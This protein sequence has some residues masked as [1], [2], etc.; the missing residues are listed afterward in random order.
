[1]SHLFISRNLQ[2]YDYPDRKKYWKTQCSNRRTCVTLLPGKVFV[3]STSNIIIWWWIFLPNGSCGRC[4]GANTV[5]ICWALHAFHFLFG[6]SIRFGRFL[7]NHICVFYPSGTL[8]L[9]YYEMST[10]HD[11]QVTLLDNNNL[12]TT[13]YWLVCI[14]LP[15]TL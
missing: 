6:V 11:T 9:Y 8:L 12:T 3:F 13:P 7:R 5:V 4:M 15:Y 14:S 1:M 10:V 2:C